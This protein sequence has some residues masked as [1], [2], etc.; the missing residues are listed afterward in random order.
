MLYS[1]ISAQRT[2]YHPQ[3]V[4]L[5]GILGALQPYIRRMNR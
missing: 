2:G 1:T 4:T 3:Y 5:H